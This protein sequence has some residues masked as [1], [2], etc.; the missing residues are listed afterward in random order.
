MMLHF[1]SK[2]LLY[3]FRFSSTSSGPF[4][5]IIASIKFL[6]SS[7]RTILNDIR[8]NERGNNW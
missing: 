3:D 2:E 7:T 8:K 6:L 5:I 1:S 4:I